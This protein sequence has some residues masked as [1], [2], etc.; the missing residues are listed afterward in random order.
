MV[1]TMQQQRASGTEELLDETRMLEQARTDPDH[2]TPFY[3][4]YF[5]RIYRYC[6]LRVGQPAEAEDLT[7]QIFISAL[8]GLQGYRRG[9]PAA[10]LFRI[11]HN[12]IA[13]HLRGRRS[14][15]T[16]AMTLL[17]S[18]AEEST[19]EEIALDH[20]MEAER[21]ARIADLITHLP[22]EQRELIA[23]RVFG[24]LSAK[25][26]GAV[27]GKREGTVHVALHRLVQ[28]LRVANEYYEKENANGS[29][30]GRTGSL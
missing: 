30:P 16:L 7:S 12:A 2:F 8:A 3:V 27:V 25:E 9:S 24:E 21:R 4:R 13:N 20:L 26:I 6:L 19:T 5:P 15:H 14:S 11:A 23:L 18:S 29:S 22:E 28:R 17:A 10:W 1:K